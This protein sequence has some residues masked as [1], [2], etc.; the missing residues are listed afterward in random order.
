M[1]IQ[2]I[3]ES[4][5]TP[6]NCVELGMT[7]YKKNPQFFIEYTQLLFSQMQ[8]SH[9]KQLIDNIANMEDFDYS[10]Y[11]NF[12]TLLEKD[13]FT[14]K[15]NLK[16]YQIMSDKIAFSFLEKNVK[17]ADKTKECHDVISFIEILPNEIE[18]SYS[19]KI[20]LFKK[21]YNEEA[22]FENIR[23]LFE[24]IIKNEHF[25]INGFMN[26]EDVKEIFKKNALSLGQ[27]T[28]MYFE[29]NKKEFYNFV[30]A[31]FILSKNTKILTPKFSVNK[32]YV[33]KLSIDEKEVEK[34]KSITQEVKIDSNFAQILMNTSSAFEIINHFISLKSYKKLVQSNNKIFTPTLLT[35]LIN[36]DKFSLEDV[37][38]ICNEEVINML[39]DDNNKNK[40]LYHLIE[41]MSV[42]IN[43]KLKFLSDSVDLPLLDIVK[44]T[45]NRAKKVARLL[46]S[47]NQVN[48]LLNLYN[49]SISN[50]SNINE[51][52]ALFSGTSLYNIIA[53]VY[54]SESYV[55]ERTVKEIENFF[56][57]VYKDIKIHEII[58]K[59]SQENYSVKASMQER[60]E[61]VQA[62]IEKKVLEE[63]QL[64]ICEKN[65]NK[66]SRK[67]KI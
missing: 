9:K 33:Y 42:S 25:T 28:A 65:E 16:E 10:N 17:K 7:L 44:I 57:L 5:Y 34:I 22:E 13:Y 19:K 67:I 66:S 20:N 50:S 43:E 12:K 40:H 56:G 1:N 23:P 45:S 47:P 15:I 55:A 39:K 35:N 21:I 4:L 18:N 32:E 46:K 37:K 52:K 29:E 64:N 60:K 31:H 30:I 24:N 58:E 48:F 41:D 36:D 11:S 49:E 3:I 63:N 2:T 54:F 6:S 61:K 62:L 8:P 59:L 26:H 27:N 53:N 51:E 38:K 14:E